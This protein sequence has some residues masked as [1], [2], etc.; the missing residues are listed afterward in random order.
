MTKTNLFRTALLIFAAALGAW[1][2]FGLGKPPPQPTVATVLPA[3]G[4]LP[5]FSL[6]DQY[7][8]PINQNNFKGSWS[9]VFFGFTHCPD[10]CPTTLQVLAAARQ[11]LATKG[12]QPLPRIVLVSVDP[13]RDTPDVIGQYV[14]YFGEG[15]VGLTGEMDELRK[16]TSGLGIYFEKSAAVADDQNY[17]VDHSAVVLVIDPRARLHALFSAPHTADAIASDMYLIMARR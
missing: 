3:P 8:Q 17:S 6:V 11:A 9:L 12:V 1:L 2:S 14:D 7:G 5:E 4:A 15:T 13:E 10:V 16:L